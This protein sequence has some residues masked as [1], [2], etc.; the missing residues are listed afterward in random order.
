M[1]DHDAGLR[2][3]Q[4]PTLTVT[5][6]FC[7]ALLIMNENRHAGN[8]AKLFLCFDDLVSMEHRGAS[9]QHNPTVFVGVVCRHNDAL[10]AFGCELADHLRHRKLTGRI[11]PTGH[12]HR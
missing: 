9:S 1:I 5:S 10:D 7:C 12:R 8:S 3:W 4:Q 6:L 11:L 2:R